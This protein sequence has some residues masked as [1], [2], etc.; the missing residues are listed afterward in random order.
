MIRLVDK[1]PQI[2]WS[3]PEISQMLLS[4]PLTVYP[5]HSFCRFESQRQPTR[6]AISKGFDIKL[7]DL[8]C[9]HPACSARVMTAT[10]KL[11]VN[12]PGPA[13]GTYTVQN[14]QCIVFC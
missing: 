14:Y 2:V 7:L 5:P 13:R 1:T 8:M 9:L 12:R 11:G 4:L 10:Q 6:T 3:R